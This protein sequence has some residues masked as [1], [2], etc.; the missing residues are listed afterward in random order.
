MEVDAT[1]HEAKRRCTATTSVATA[2]TS[3]AE[4]KAARCAD[5]ANK[6]KEQSRDKGAE[7]DGEVRNPRD[8]RAQEHCQRH[9]KHRRESGDGAAP[10]GFFWLF[11]NGELVGDKPCAIARSI[12][13]GEW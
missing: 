13:V 2:A 6:R 11:A 10:P 7:S 9:A 12:L 3:D 1:T 5:T 8:T 4:A